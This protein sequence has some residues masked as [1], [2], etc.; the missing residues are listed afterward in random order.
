MFQ[1]I[2]SAFSWSKNP[3][4]L[5]LSYLRE[6]NVQEVHKILFSQNPPRLQDVQGTE[7]YKPNLLIMSIHAPAIVAALLD[8]YEDISG[9]DRS[10]AFLQA[11]N[12]G[13][14]QTIEVLLD[15]SAAQISNID[16]EYAFRLAVENNHIPLIVKLLTRCG[17]QINAQ[18]KKFA[19]LDAAERGFVVAFFEIFTRVSDNLS[20][21]DKN[22]VFE[23][24]AENGYVDDLNL[25]L[26]SCIADKNQALVFSTDSTKAREKPETIEREFSGPRL[27]RR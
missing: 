26:V 15:K 1:S 27:C 9:R 4:S 13:H 3:A 10:E 11:A 22:W 12:G 5:L 21:D 23:V 24:I 2:L 14:V 8:T 7:G 18:E 25:L 17:N 19:L 6:G 16:K 20:N